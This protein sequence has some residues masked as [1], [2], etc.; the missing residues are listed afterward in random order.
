MGI[1][2]CM[3]GKKYKTFGDLAM[4]YLNSLLNCFSQSNEVVDVFDRY[5]TELSIKGTERKL[6]ARRANCTKVYQVLESRGLPDLKK[7]L[8]VEEN[9]RQLV[10][11]LGSFVEKVVCMS[12]RVP[13]GKT[14]YMA[15]AFD[16]PDI[17]KKF[18]TE[19]VNLCEELGSTQEEADT[20]IILHLI[21][22]DSSFKRSG[23]R[24]RVIV[25]S[26]DTDV[27]VLC[28]HF[29]QK[30]TNTDELWIQKGHCV[31]D[32]KKFVP[33]HDI[34]KALPSH[35]PKVLPV[36]HAL[37]GCDTVSSMYGIGKK[38]VF[39]LM[40]LDVEICLGLEDVEDGM[41]FLNACRRFVARLYDAKSK[42]KDSHGDLN[43]L[44]YKLATAKEPSLA[45]L[46]PS[47]MAFREHVERARLQSIIWLNADVAVA[48]SISPTDHGWSIEEGTLCPVP[49]K[50]NMTE[51][52]LNEL[53]CQCKGKKKCHDNCVCRSRQ[54]P[55]TELC[56]CG[57]LDMCLNEHTH[58]LIVGKQMEGNEELVD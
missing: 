25:Q 7:F 44:R 56:V 23:T 36:L 45:R 6:R 16:N 10:S 41:I 13:N 55:C 49:F 21:N 53:I 18:T 35:V 4:G 48:P 52:I 57:G 33:V 20:R 39:K 12:E 9:K 1:V 3:D 8:A 51:D 28:C 30:L 58:N 31:R 2:Q 43:K 38:S 24:G 40:C 37:S 47:E 34:Y 19:E 15:G 32:G 22:I 29:L 42:Y 50:G 54:F 26:S 17:V 46:P 5:D 14:L 27:L 11:F